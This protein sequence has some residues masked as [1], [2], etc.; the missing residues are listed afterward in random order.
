M[1]TSQHHLAAVCS[2]SP[3]WVQVTWWHAAAKN[4][5]AII[6]AIKKTPNR[7]SFF[8]WTWHAAI[9]RTLYPDVARRVPTGDGL[10]G[11]VPVTEPY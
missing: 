5:H 4:N 9:Y 1:T 11:I 7:G 10:M 3:H 2:C 6:F 8:Y